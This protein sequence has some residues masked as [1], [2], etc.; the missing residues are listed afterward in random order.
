MFE[1]IPQNSTDFSTV[2][3]QIPSG[4]AYNS[5]A[6]SIFALTVPTF[7]C[8]A[9]P[10]TFPEMLLLHSKTH[11]KTPLRFWTSPNGGKVVPLFHTH[12][13]RVFRGF[14][15]EFRVEFL[16]LFCLLFNRA[17]RAISVSRSV[18]V[19]SIMTCGSSHAMQ[20]CPAAV[21]PSLFILLESPFF[22]LFLFSFPNDQ[23]LTYAWITGLIR[24]RNIL[25]QL[26]ALILWRERKWETDQ[27]KN[28]GLK[29]ICF[30]FLL[31]CCKDIPTFSVG[32]ITDCTEWFKA[33]S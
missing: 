22:F 20:R 32:F 19:P 27:E 16:F 6:Q 21:L 14:T 11:K 3:P 17:E 31:C 8:S 9:S 30:L 33:F 25:Y 5:N 24:N 10:A 7:I 12:F 13:G 15:E 26:P 2:V 4:P 28:R 1:F 29:R 23:C 18:K